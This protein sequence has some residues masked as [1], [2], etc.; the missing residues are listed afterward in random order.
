LK[1]YAR[2][3]KDFEAVQTLKSWLRDNLDTNFDGW[4]SNDAWDAARAARRTAYNEWIQ[5]AKEAESRGEDMTVAK[6]DE[7]LPFDT[8]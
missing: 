1:Q 2:E 4:V 7:M 3:Y 6:A 8:S 5:T